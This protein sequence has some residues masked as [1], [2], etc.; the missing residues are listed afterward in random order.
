MS[1]M[2][3]RN[4]AVPLLSPEDES[5]RTDRSDHGKYT[6]WVS[7]QPQ[8][9]F[10]KFAYILLGITGILL[11]VGA[12]IGSMVG[13]KKYRNVAFPHRAVHASLAQSKGRTDIV[14]SYFQPSSS[15]SNQDVRLIMNVWFREG[16]VP[17]PAPGEDNSTAF[18]YAEWEAGRKWMYG[19]QGFNLSER[20]QDNQWESI[21]TGELSD[22]SSLEAHHTENVRLVLPGRIV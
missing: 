6:K 14:E 21:W 10:R 5:S 15:G 19:G 1:N 20:A 8:V 11:L 9:S 2:L 16:T 7:L 12:V 3:D 18:Y 4:S 22:V 13:V 17:R